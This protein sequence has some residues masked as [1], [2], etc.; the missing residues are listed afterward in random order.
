MPQQTLRAADSN[1]QQPQLYSQ[2]SQDCTLPHILHSISLASLKAKD[3]SLTTS[4]GSTVTEEFTRALRKS[5]CHRRYLSTSAFLALPGA[6]L[7]RE[8]VTRFDSISVRQQ[9]TS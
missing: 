6:A 4:A 7:S 1:Q 9:P 2:E 5:T 3:S 8:R